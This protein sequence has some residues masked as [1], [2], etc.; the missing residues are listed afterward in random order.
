MQR[1][2]VSNLAQIGRTNYI[3]FPMQFG[4]G[5]EWIFKIPAAG[6]VEH[7]DQSAAQALESEALSMRMLRQATSMPKP[8]VHAFDVVH[9]DE[10]TA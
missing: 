5:L 1:G 4:D 6:V 10:R 9:K 8:A 7:W 2:K 3:L